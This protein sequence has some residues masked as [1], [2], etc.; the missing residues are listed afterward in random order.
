[1]VPQF[2][3]GKKKK[4]AS[5]LSCGTIVLHLWKFKRK[6][7]A[8]VLLNLRILFSNLAPLPLTITSGIHAGVVKIYKTF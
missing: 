2:N 6:I 1:M 8:K 3:R 7:H 4:G 5:M